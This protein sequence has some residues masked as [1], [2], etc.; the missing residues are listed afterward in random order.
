MKT[1]FIF[2]LVVCAATLAAAAD[3][4]TLKADRKPETEQQLLK[5]ER[6]WNEAFKAQDKTA[7]SALCAEDFVATDAEGATSNK[8]SYLEDAVKQVKVLSYSLSNT[9]AR[10]YGDSGIVT[11]RWK[12]KVSVQG[13]VTEFAAA[14]TDTFVRRDGRWW[15]VAT[16]MSRLPVEVN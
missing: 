11:G 6:D 16:H 4:A 3:I 12:G 8:P 2:A 5:V 9:S 14:F 1:L 10:A 7:L 15:A 13:Q